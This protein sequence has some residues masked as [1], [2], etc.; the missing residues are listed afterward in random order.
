MVILPNSGASMQHVL[1]VWPFPHFLIAIALAQIGASFGRYGAQAA[2]WALVAIAAANLLLINQ[3]Y[4]D[5]VTNGTSAI[6]TT[7]IYPLHTYL[8][9]AIAPRI[10]STDWRYAT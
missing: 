2:A 9:S 6:W 7:A 3:Y 10:L 1:L 8:E 4:S 5:L